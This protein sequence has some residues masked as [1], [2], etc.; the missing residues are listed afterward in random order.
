[1]K[2]FVPGGNVRHT[3]VQLQLLFMHWCPDLNFRGASLPANI[4]M[5]VPID[6]LNEGPKQQGDVCVRGGSRNE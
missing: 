3:A 1:M 6:A 2:A 4:L 5:K